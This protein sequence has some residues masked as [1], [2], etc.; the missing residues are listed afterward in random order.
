MRL[1]E[2]KTGETGVVVKILGHGAFRKR[3]ME[4]GFVKG[5]E[6]KSLLNAPLNDPIKYSIMGYELSLRRSEADLV[7]VVR[8]KTTDKD[9][10][11][12]AQQ[13]VDLPESI[14]EETDDIA[15]DDPHEHARRTQRTINI[16]LVGNPNCGK[17]SL[18]NIASGA[19]EHVGNY[20]GV[21]VDAKRGHFSYGGYRF[22]IVDLPGTYSLACYSPEEL[23]V[24]RYLRDEMPDI[25]VN[26]VV[27]SNLERN[28]Y[29]TTELIDMDRS[30]VIALNMYDELEHSGAT[31]DYRMLG[32]MIGVPMVPTVSRTGEGLHNLF[33]TIIRVY[34]G[35]ENAVRHVH[36][37]LGPE[38]EPSVTMVKDAIKADPA[39]G[40]HFSPRYL[41]IKLLEHDSEVEAIVKE[42][43]DHKKLLE[44]RDQCDALIEKRTGDDVS[45]IIASEKYGF[46]DGALAET[47]VDSTKEKAKTTHIIDAFVTNR[48][49]GFPIFLA[50]M[51]FMF[52]CTFEI[53]SY[54]MAWIESAV[55]WI[56]GL[57][58]TYMPEG[59]LK[60][61]VADG[62]I[63][64][65]GGV[66][67]FLPNILILYFFISFM[68]DS[69]YMARAAF[70]MDKLMHRIGLHGKSFIPL[71]MGFGC[72]V[73]AIMAARAIESRSS[74]II[75]VLI[76]PFM[77]CSARLPVYVL[78]V[79]TFFSKHAALVFLSLYLLGILV[80]IVTARLLRRFWFK[81]D[82][83]P[84]VMELPPYRLPTL[85]SS[86]RHMWGKGEQY[87]KKMG[88]I[89]LVASIIVWV[90]NYFPLHDDKST[91]GIEQLT[92]GDDSRINPD[93]D[94]YLQML[95]K[96]VNPVMEPLG[97]HWRSTVAVL[98]GAPAKEI[99]VSTLGVL[100]TGDEEIDDTALSARLTAP[101]PATGKPDFNA[102]NALSL[103]VFVL[104]YFPCMAT[105]VAIVRETGSWRYGAFS[106]VY[107]TLAAWIVAFLVYQGALLIG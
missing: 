44:L 81:T 60:D 87:L 24:R 16:A 41:A 93:S 98:A 48:L 66:I 8:L 45:G 64:G 71:V 88:G 94:S 95:G 107:N 67:V 40:V 11:P 51:L 91:A 38:I 28:L 17:T 18:F 73:P 25:V 78:L 50:I 56:A 74:R 1:S 32:E 26:V 102:A 106:V 80:A 92:P 75:T 82:E 35:K 68:E 21:T 65:V 76:N 84:F 100:Y 34:E 33:D 36:V 7:E 62:I 72:N 85:K 53:G 22:N 5:Q 99:V 105:V 90:L 83:T 54:P 52:W 96:A 2:L 55:A 23:Y 70:I 103:M 3:V 77:S 15:S 101:N 10:R 9:T 12:R 47:Y 58:E 59:P 43:P 63:G 30:M 97:F 4:M 27:A 19:K 14:L 79:G 29:L 39:I 31:I 6:I 69:G 42:S 49:F 57:V 61:L 20:S 104:L 46:I 37:N 89:I 13:G 86:L